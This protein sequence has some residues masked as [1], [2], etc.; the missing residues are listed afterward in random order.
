MRK[1]AER[2]QD[3][4]SRCLKPVAVDGR[5]LWRAGIKYELSLKNCRTLT[6]MVRRSLR[7]GSSC[8]GTSCRHLNRY[9]API[10]AHMQNSWQRHWLGTQSPVR[11]MAG[12]DSPRK[13]LAAA[14]VVAAS[15]SGEHPLTCAATSECLSHS[16]L[17]TFPTVRTGAR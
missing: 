8:S 2:L 16:G 15:S 5:P 3:G 6:Q 17:A 4:M 13:S 7:N 10:R 14:Q 12:Y 1:L 11:L 9:L